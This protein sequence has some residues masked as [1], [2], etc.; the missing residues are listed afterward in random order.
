M[1]KNERVS[2]LPN[3]ELKAVKRAANALRLLM[4]TEKKFVEMLDPCSMT[5]YSYLLTLLQDIH[6]AIRRLLTIKYDSQRSSIFEG[7]NLGK[8]SIFRTKS[9]IDIDSIFQNPAGIQS[10]SHCVLCLRFCV[11]TSKF[12][13]P[14]SLPPHSKTAPLDQKDGLTFVAKVHSWTMLPAH[15]NIHKHNTIKTKNMCV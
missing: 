8:H 7:F 9:K 6:F 13:E 2:R 4:G 11:E 15:K 10:T 1:R 3:C 12:R 5:C 14:S